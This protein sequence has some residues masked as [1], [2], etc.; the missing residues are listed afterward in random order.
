MIVCLLCIY[1]KLLD[2]LFHIIYILYSSL[3]CQPTALYFSQSSATAQYCNNGSNSRRWKS[4][5]QSP[6]AIVHEEDALHPKDRPQEQGVCNWSIAHCL[7]QMIHI[8]AECKPAAQKCWDGNKRKT[9]EDKGDDHRRTL[10]VGLEDV[11]DL[12]ELAIAQG[13]VGGWLRRSRIAS[14]EDVEGKGVG[15]CRRAEG[16][17]NQRSLERFVGGEKL[18]GEVLVCLFE[19]R[20]V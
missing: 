11:V 12:G 19:V 16:A 7:R 20:T 3:P 13:L 2:I 6:A 14:D 17:N 15:W 18:V 9:G 4:L 5:E 1:V 8:R 10:R